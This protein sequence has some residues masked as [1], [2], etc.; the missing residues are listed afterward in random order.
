MHLFSS[1]RRLAAHYAREGEYY[2]VEVKLSEARRLFNSLDPAPFI[3][4]DLDSDAE[5]YIVDMV[6]DFPL[7]TPLKLLIH[8][9][10]SEC[11][12]ELAASMPEAVRNYF[13]YL[14]HHADMKLRFM[15]LQGRT[16]LLIGL[17]FLFACIAAR[18]VVLTLGEGLLHDMIGEGLLICGWVAMWRPIQIYLYDWWPIRRMNLIYQKIRLMPIEVS[19][20]QVPGSSVR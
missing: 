9:P 15:L 18:E 12:S 20:I 19:P 5:S 17:L 8:L 14:A 1:P 11:G 2:L 16:S 13:A 10:E 4:K 7:S 3:E 6:Q